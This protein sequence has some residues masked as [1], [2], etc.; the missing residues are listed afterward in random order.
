MDI[1]D[2]AMKALIAKSCK[3]E[4]KRLLEIE[5]SDLSEKLVTTEIKKWKPEIEKEIK[6]LLESKKKELIKS[7]VK[8]VCKFAYI[9]EG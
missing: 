8:K 7:F 9:E 2:K 5:I 6:R 1:T 3:E 4:T